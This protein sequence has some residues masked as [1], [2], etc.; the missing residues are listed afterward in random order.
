MGLKNLHVKLEDSQHQRFRLAVK[1]LGYGSMAS[2]VREQ[3]RR[4][5]KDAGV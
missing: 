4:A 3:V 1:K 5:I 2:Y